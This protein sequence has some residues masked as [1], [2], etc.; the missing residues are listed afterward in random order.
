MT[1]DAAGQDRWLDEIEHLVG[2]TYAAVDQVPDDVVARA[3]ALLRWRTAGDVSFVVAEVDEAA[4][5]VR[6]PGDAP[7]PLR[8]RSTAQTIEISVERDFL[9]GSIEPWEDGTMSIETDEGVA[10]VV[11]D[12][13]GWFRIPTPAARRARLR[14]VAEDGAEQISAWF[15]LNRGRS[16]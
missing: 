5:A 6:G 14:V 4:V 3:A 11:V 10:A 1:S 16:S 2:E 9:I 8:F 7:A 15:R 13:L 12:D